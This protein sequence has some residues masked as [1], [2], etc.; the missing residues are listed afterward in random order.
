MSNIFLT[1]LYVDWVVP[2]E[3]LTDEL[4]LGIILFLI[5]LL[6]ITGSSIATITILG[7]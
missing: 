7:L 3:F 1:S 5:L 2:G 4:G 6:G